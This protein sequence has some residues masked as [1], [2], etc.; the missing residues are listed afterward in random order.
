MLFGQEISLLWSSFELFMTVTHLFVFFGI[1]NS[2]L[3]FLRK[4]KYY[5]LLDAT[6]HT[7]NLLVYFDR[8]SSIIMMFSLCLWTIMLIGHL[9][10]FLNL[11]RNPPLSLRQRLKYDGS[12][13]DDRHKIS[14][15]FHWSCIEYSKDRFDITQSGKEMLETLGDITAHSTGFY[16]AFQNLESLRYRSMTFILMVGLLYR[17]MLNL[18]HFINEPKMMPQFMRKFSSLIYD[19]SST[20]HYE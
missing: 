10:Y 8:K 2:K 4:Q 14:R 16:L 6:T 15:I 20:V 3:D 13:P 1:R 5:F 12:I 19:H 17:Q 11:H 7:G 18:P 9:H